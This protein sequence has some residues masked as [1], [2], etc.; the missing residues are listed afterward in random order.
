MTNDFVP[1]KVIYIII[2]KCIDYRCFLLNLHT[3]VDQTV[4]SDQTYAYLYSEQYG[5]QLLP[6][7]Q[8]EDYQQSLHRSVTL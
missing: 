5:S 1:A 2:L 8:T 6:L 3:T 4:K 7:Y